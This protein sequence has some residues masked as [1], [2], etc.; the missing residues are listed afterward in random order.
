MSEAV[1]LHLDDRLLHGR[2]LHGWGSV[3]K[4]RRYVLVSATLTCAERR[5]LYR[6]NAAGTKLLCLSPGAAM[7]ETPPAPEDGDFW[8]TDSPA[9]ALWLHEAGCPFRRLLLLGLRDAA[10]IVLG[11]GYRADA[12]H[13]AQLRALALRGVVVELRPF[14]GAPGRPLPGDGET[15]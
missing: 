1:D 9:A 15:H 12:S 14:P 6:Q 13:L 4:P 7:N 3:L 2:V 10:G 8:L 11:D 5:Q